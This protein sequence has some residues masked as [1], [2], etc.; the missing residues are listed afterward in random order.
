MLSIWSGPK[1]CRV[2]M[3]YWL[4][5]K[6]GIPIYTEIYP[7][8]VDSL[9]LVPQSGLTVCLEACQLWWAVYGCFHNVVILVCLEPSLF[10]GQFIAG[11]TVRSIKPSR[12]ICQL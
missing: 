6:Y 2:G 1:F 4:V 11:L 12:K 9:R 3:G 7:F 8:V 10:V 5:L